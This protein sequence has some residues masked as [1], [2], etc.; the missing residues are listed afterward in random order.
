MYLVLILVVGVVCLFLFVT[1]YYSALIDAWQAHH[2]VGGAHCFCTTST[3]TAN[4]SSSRKA[5]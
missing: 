2:I 1:I 3:V 4:Q 5:A